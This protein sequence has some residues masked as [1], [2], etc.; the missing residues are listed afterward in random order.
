MGLTKILHILITSQ[1]QRTTLL[2]PS[3]ASAG[4][5]GLVDH[6]TISCSCGDEG[7]AIGE[8]SEAGV[9]IEGYVRQTIAQSAE[10]EGEVADEPAESGL[11]SLDSLVHAFQEIENGEKAYWSVCARCIS[12]WPR[13]I[14][15][16]G[17]GAI[18]GV[19]GM[20]L[21]M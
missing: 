1:R 20:D 17:G 9:E 6:D 16:G 2:R 4:T 19:I 18:V 5:I 12:L 15:A 14:V 8:A 3:R 13:G 7:G 10:E 11:V 21:W